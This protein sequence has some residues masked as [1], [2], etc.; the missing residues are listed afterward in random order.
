MSELFEAA[1]RGDA[2]GVARLVAEDASRLEYRSDAEGTSGWSALHVAAREGHEGCVEALLRAAPEAFLRGRTARQSTALAVAANYGRVQV[3]RMLMDA[4]TA[5]EFDA[6]IV[7]ASSGHEAVVA[8]A[9]ERG[10]ADVGRAY[11]KNESTP[12]HMSARLGHAGVVRLLLEA[13]ADPLAV[14]PDGYTPLMMSA[15]SGSAEVF[16][17]LAGAAGGVE[18][19]ARHR[20]EKLGRTVLG[21]ASNTAG[22]DG[23]VR[24]LVAAGAD[25]FEADL[26]GWTPAMAALSRN[27]ADTAVALLEGISGPA[28]GINGARPDGATALHFSALECDDRR[29]AELLI[30]AGADVEAVNDN[31]NTPLHV[32]SRK[33]H[34]GPAAALLAAGASTAARNK[35]GHTPALLAAGDGHAGVLALLADAGAS[36][37]DAMPD[38]GTTAMHFAARNGHTA[39]VRELLAR[40]VDVKAARQSGETP[41]SE[42]VYHGHAATAEALLEAG[43]DPAVFPPPHRSLV[44]MIVRREVDGAAATVRLL[45]GPR[46]GCDPNAR[47][48]GGK[49]VLV[50]ACIQGRAATAEALLE[51]GADPNADCDGKGG[52]TALQVAAILGH[53]GIIR[54]LLAA[55]AVP[56]RG[57]AA[58]F[59]VEQGHPDAVRELVPFVDDAEQQRRMLRAAAKSGSVAMIEAVTAAGG[60]PAD[61]ADDHADEGAPPVFLAAASGHADSVRALVAA[62]ASPDAPSADGYTTLFAAVNSGSAS[63]VDALVECGVS[64]AALAPALVFAAKRGDAEVLDALLRNGADPDSVLDETGVFALGMAAHA[65]AGLPCLKRLLRA[66][67]DPN[68]ASSDGS[69]ALYSAS[70]MGTVPQV[71]ALLAAGADVD[72]RRSAGQTPLLAACAKGHATVVRLLLEA[73]ADAEAAMNTGATPLLMAALDGS[74]AVVRVLLLNGADARTAERAGVTPLH[75]AAHKN[76]APIVRLL[77]DSGADP[78][79]VTDAGVT[80]VEVARRSGAA[81]AIRV[82]PAARDAAA[83]AAGTA[84]AMAAAGDGDAVRR[85]LE[86]QRAGLARLEARLAGVADGELQAMAGEARQRFRVQEERAR[87][88]GG[89]AGV[90][91]LDYYRYLHELL[92]GTV[93]AAR[94]VHSGLVAAR[95]GAALSTTADELSGSLRRVAASA[96]DAAAEHA[97]LPLLGP[98]CRLLSRVLR[99]GDE[100]ALKRQLN[101]LAVCVAPGVAPEAAFEPLARRLALV[102]GP[103][104]AAAAHDAARKST[105]LL[106]RLRG[107]AREASGGDAR[108]APR[109]AAAADGRKALFALL[110]GD[111]RE[112]LVDAGPRSTHGLF[113]A[114]LPGED[115]GAPVAQPRAAVPAPAPPIAA[116]ADDDGSFTDPELLSGPNEEFL[117]MQAELA[118]S[119]KRDARVQQQLAELY[120]RLEKEG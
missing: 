81:D 57:M 96:L 66:G 19:A 41:L 33:G 101:R 20:N 9:L 64:A 117:R 24:R 55:G 99:L 21:V 30:S 10:K 4:E 119:R 108:T 39:V 106:A 28:A 15:A 90:E 47:D 67:A 25:P 69:T 12:L 17:L 32:A 54:T 63:V 118:E 109:D 34:A 86:R 107:K 98:V 100:A 11:G 44:E 65:D 120:A 42:A 72:A 51:G 40:G 85:E 52:T 94:V 16:D 78:L 23:V 62:G 112:A 18:A 114:V 26:R 73:G 80:P 115:F 29:P 27:R 3:A 60:V 95:P 2:E 49:P 88:L 35:K 110:E 82:L 36:L 97:P 1:E 58:A 45:L 87:L 105:G 43:A 84:R 102:R 116:S 71:R 13:K 92:T 89:E 38:T 50:L 61:A 93:V 103:G 79:A 68:S 31:G 37:T 113:C 76:H 70:V 56:S 75:L 7:G 104:L 53:A 8:L 59:A 83:Q 74:A 46:G 111:L 6:L 14:R 77:L 48:K 5:D 22:M 91:A